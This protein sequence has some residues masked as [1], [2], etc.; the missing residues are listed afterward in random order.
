MPDGSGLRVYSRVLLILKYLS[1]LTSSHSFLPIG[2]VRISS[3][4]KWDGGDCKWDCASGMAETVKWERAD[5]TVQVGLHEWD[6]TS[7]TAQ[8]A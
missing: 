4:C 5:R 6:S 1:E 3:P 7:G 8:V 2:V